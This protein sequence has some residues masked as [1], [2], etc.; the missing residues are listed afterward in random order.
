MPSPPA[1]TRSDLRHLGDFAVGRRVLV[2]A[3]FALPIGAVGA[4]LAW[5]LLRLIG[6]V[7]NLV[8]YDR[9]ATALIAPGAVPH[10]PLLILLAPVC[11][12][13]S[14]N[15]QEAVGGLGGDAV[16]YST[17]TP[18]ALLGGGGG[19][20]SR[21]NSSGVA[22]SGA[23]GGGIVMLRA[24]SVSGSGTINADGAD[25]YNDTDND[26]GGGGG[27][28]G[29]VWVSVTTGSLAGLTANARGGRGGNAWSDEP[30]NGTPGARHG[31]GGGGGGGLVA[32]TGGAA[33]NVTG[34]N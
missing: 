34:G 5:A 28:G 11:G 22:G 27:A 13:N 25:A 3:A 8:F 19:A 21:N 14:W 7:T 32:H 12:G 33:V 4:G 24:A 23:S 9:F 16:T 1:P 18:M 30:A 2:I 20:G 10:P 31:P 6:L 26:G 17:A 29:S 15:S